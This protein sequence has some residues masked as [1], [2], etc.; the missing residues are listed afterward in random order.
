MFSFFK[1]KPPVEAPAPSPAPVTAAPLV[2][3]VAAP[4]PKPAPAPPPAPE[5]ERKSWVSKLTA[6]LRKTGGMDVRASSPEE[7]R[8]MVAGQVAR[9]KKVVADANIPQQ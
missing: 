4:S 1:K 5:P 9:W 2:A 8:T 6:G 3:P 7:M